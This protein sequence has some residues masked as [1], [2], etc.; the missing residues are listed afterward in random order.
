MLV[1]AIVIITLALAL[2]TIGVWGERIQGILKWWHV[3]FLSGSD[4][5]PMPP[6]P[7]S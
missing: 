3:V 4:L 1:P 5:P 7:S 6:A 2:Y